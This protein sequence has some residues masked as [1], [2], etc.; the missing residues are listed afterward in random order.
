[1]TSTALNSFLIAAADEPS[2]RAAEPPVA[3]RVPKTDEV[4]GDTRVDDYFWLRDKR[5]PEVAAYLEAEN[6]YTD[7]VMA[8]TQPLQDALYKEMLA[9]IKETDVNVPYRKGGYFYYSR[10]EQGQQYPIYCRKRG[11]LDAPEEVTLDLN[12]LAEG[13]KFMALGAYQVSDNGSRLAYTTD[14]TGFRQSPLYVKDLGTQPLLPI[15]VE[16]VGSVAWA[17]DGQ[18]LFYTVEDEQTKRQYRLY[19]HRLGTEA[20]DL[21]YEEKDEAFNIGVG[22]TRS[23]KYLI[24]GMGSLTT[25]EARYLPAD[26]PAGEWRM[27]APRIPDQEYDV[28]HHGDLFYIRANDTGRNFRLVAAPVASPGREHWK[29]VVPHRADVMLEGVDFFRNHSVLFEREGGLTEL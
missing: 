28:E 23:Q 15:R 24:L 16:R 14:A 11:S 19:R 3:R 29:E 1:M 10:T 6:A 8:P 2:A 4:H 13:Q 9:R 25:S 21:V 27:I 22:R 7:A 17:A 5:N 18:T 26:H 12:G 20:H